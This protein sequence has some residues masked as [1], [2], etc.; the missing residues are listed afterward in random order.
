MIKITDDLH[1]FYQATLLFQVILNANRQ[2]LGLTEASLNEDNTFHALRSCTLYFVNIL[3]TA[4][5][6]FGV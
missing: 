2:T 4:I 1:L 6:L 5:C 3:V